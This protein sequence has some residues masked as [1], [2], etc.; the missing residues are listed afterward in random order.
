MSLT[1]RSDG[2]MLPGY[3]HSGDRG[4]GV[5][6]STIS[7][8]G[9]HGPAIPYPSL[10]PGDAGKEIMIR[11]DVVPPLLT[12]FI[13]DE[14]G[15]V[16]AE[17]PPGIHE[18]QFTA[19]ADGE[20]A[21]PNPSAAFFVLIGTSGFATGNLVAE[22]AVASGAMSNNPLSILAGTVAAEDAAAGGSLATN[23][24]SVLTGGLVADD[25]APIGTVQGYVAPVA[26]I[27]RRV[28][29]VGTR[30][31][32]TRLEGL[33]VSEIDDIACRFGGVLREGEIVLS[34]SVTAEP[35]VGVDPTPVPLLA[36]LPQNFGADCIQRVDGAIG[37]PGVTYLVTFVAALNS[38]RTEVGEAFLRIV[39]RAT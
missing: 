36:A 7:G 13:V 4:L 30:T 26:I 29:L 24:P 18:G 1:H 38:G 9:T 33:N 6:G 17:G 23:P 16:Q 12:L 21:T 8:S 22:D 28:V 3:H 25:A 27:G 11:I 5:L 2:P 15:N 37:V 14:A 34:Y 31:T 19:W 39:R 10:Q 32:P 20:L 35:V